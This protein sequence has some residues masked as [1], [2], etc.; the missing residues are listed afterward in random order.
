MIE[1]RNTR[2]YDLPLAA[3]ISFAKD[4]QSVSLLNISIG[5]FCFKS[6]ALLPTNAEIQFSIDLLGTAPRSNDFRVRGV[7]KL[8]HIECAGEAFSIGVEIGRY[9]MSLVRWKPPY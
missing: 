6:A 5:G 2:R 1:R 9:E 8:T 4:L 7:G 3:E